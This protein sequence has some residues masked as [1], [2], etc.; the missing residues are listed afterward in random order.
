[1]DGKPV[2]LI[3]AAINPTSGELVSHPGLT[4]GG[5][6]LRREI[7][8]EVAIAVIDELLNTLR[9]WGHKSLTIKLLPQVFST[10]PSAELGYVLW[11][12]GFELVRRDLSSILPLRDALPFNSL[13]TRGVK[14]ARKAGLVIGEA[15][16]ADFHPLLESVLLSQHGVKPVHT[17]SEMEL[18]I[19]RFPSKIKIRVARDKNEV[20]AG[21]VIFDY[22]HIWH[23]QYLA[24]SNEGR[25]LGAL[26]FVIDGVKN[27][28]IVNKVE[29]LS[30]GAS[31]ESSGRL[32][33]EGLLWQ[34]ESFGARS[35]NL[36]FMEGAL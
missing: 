12:R 5:V 16:P 20:M 34:K 2:A 36:D 18:L 9:E 22:G 29:Y 35:L 1:M 6:V 11:R 32:L 21:T 7:R 31:T 3:P 25:S 15:T 19:S 17:K 14:K 28:A 26:D 10:Y 23:T 4:F 27:E 30:F 24:C 33:N 13:K 8:G